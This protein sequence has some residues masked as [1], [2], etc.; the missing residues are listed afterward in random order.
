[1]SIRSVPNPMSKTG[2]IVYGVLASLAGCAPTPASTAEPIPTPITTSQSTLPMVG[3]KARCVSSR[4]ET[5]GQA[6]VRLK[7]HHLSAATDRT[8]GF[9]YNN[10]GYTDP[11]GR[12]G[13]HRPIYDEE[14]SAGSK[15]ALAAAFDFLNPA[16]QHAMCENLDYV[17]VDDN[18]GN[19][20]QDGDSGMG[21][22]FWEVTLKQTQDYRLREP[23]PTTTEDQADGHGRFIAIPGKL[24]ANLPSVQQLLS[25]TVERIL[26]R[27]A[28]DT[29]ITVASTNGKQGADERMKRAALAAVMLHELG[30]VL[31]FQT[32]VAG[33]SMK[34]DAFRNVGWRTDLTWPKS[35]IHNPQLPLGAIR[36]GQTAPGID[37]IVS[38]AS[39]GDLDPL[40]ELLGVGPL[41]ATTSTNWVSLL[42]AAA[43][44][45][46]F[47][48]TLTVLGLQR[49]G[50][51][52]IYH[53]PGGAF[54]TRS[55]ARSLNPTKAQLAAALLPTLL[56]SFGPA[57]RT[58]RH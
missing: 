35:G 28:P 46:D 25:T 29:L 49:N 45:E 57:G 5:P 52:V 7:V 3:H 30:H 36:T 16:F 58:A 21:W 24:M 10:N 22:A 34:C 23:V 38:A 42:S 39:T 53:G 9:K 33:G 32:C 14:L 43:P 48:E 50:L 40:Y 55:A 27:R 56:G 11:V 12:Q 2:L 31:W 18:E 41:K 51:Q 47:A 13:Y 54:R 37:D 6:F 8:T 17:F 19:F 15:A 26:G 4:G 20:T 1:M 44:D